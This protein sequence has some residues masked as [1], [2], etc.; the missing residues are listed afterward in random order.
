[1]CSDHFAPWS[2][3]QG[4]S[5]YAWS[6]LGAALARTRLDLGVV[7]APGQRY[8]PA[9]LAQAAATLA[10][11]YPGRFWV[12]LGSGQ[13]L[14]EHITGERW[15]S[16]EAR[17]ERLAECAAV[18]KGLL[19]GETVSHDG[20]VRVDRARLWS[21]PP[22]PPPVLAAAVTPATAKAVAEWAE[23]VVTFNQP[24]EAHAETLAAYR[25]A[26]GEGPAYL[27]V[28]L[29]WA[30]SMERAVAIAHDQWREAIFGSDAGWEL[31]LPEHLEQAA[32]FVRPDDVERFVHCSADPDEHAEWLGRQASHGF[33]RILIHHV[34]QTQ[35]PFIE[36]FGAL[37]LPRL[38]GDAE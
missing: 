5:G 4:H 14:N 20:H 36:A 31:A 17:D 22:A 38:A 28:H 2:E 3:R 34:G 9:V 8:H 11:M 29:S 18:V 26:G 12:A 13:A 30:E 23:G 27:Q 19:A 33:D 7:S 21:L 15:P 10:D 6:W 37:V 25:E 35:R 24:D 1:M 32:E 16:K